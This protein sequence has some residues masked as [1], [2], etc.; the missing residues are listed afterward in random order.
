LPKFLVQ[1][2][3]VPELI[4]DAKML[5]ETSG[6]CLECNNVTDRRQTDDRQTTDG[7]FMP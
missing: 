2:V 4:G 7:Q 5:P 6:L 1:I 3:R